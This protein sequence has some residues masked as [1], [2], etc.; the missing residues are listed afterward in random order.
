MPGQQEDQEEDS[1]S[2]E[3]AEKESAEFILGEYVSLSTTDTPFLAKLF[4]R[5]SKVL[6]NHL[7][8]ILMELF[9]TLGNKSTSSVDFEY[10][11]GVKGHA[12]IIPRVKSED[13]FRRQAKKFNWIESILEHVSEK[14]EA[15]QWMSCYFGKNMKDPS[16]L[17]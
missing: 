1:S 16:L 7:N 5:D 2:D 15:A 14:N 4:G 3:S 17:P 9:H 11:N 12:V 13:S 10:K 8:I 6:K